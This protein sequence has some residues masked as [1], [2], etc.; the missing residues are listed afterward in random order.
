MIGGLPDALPVLQAILHRGLGPPPAPIVELAVF[1]VLDYTRGPASQ[2]DTHASRAHR[3]RLKQAKAR[4]R[5]ARRVR[6]I[7]FVSQGITW[8]IALPR[9][10]PPASR[11]LLDR[12]RTRRTRGTAR[13]AQPG[14]LAMR[15]GARPAPLEHTKTW[16]G[17]PPVSTASQAPF[18]CPQASHF[19][20]C[21][22]DRC[23]LILRL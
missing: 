11:A 4:K 2:Q 3:T 10:T 8:W 9:Q 19:V 21:V 6:A 1:A 17:R 5:P 7:L 14:R 15:P 20:T 16:K 23:S 18:R 22:M 13:R 12:P